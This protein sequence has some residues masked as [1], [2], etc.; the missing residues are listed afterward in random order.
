MKPIAI[1]KQTVMVKSKSKTFSKPSP[2]RDNY[3]YVDTIHTFVKKMFPRQRDFLKYGKNFSGRVC[4][5]EKIICS[6]Y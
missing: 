3:I 1:L 4:P 2:F 6:K 5:D